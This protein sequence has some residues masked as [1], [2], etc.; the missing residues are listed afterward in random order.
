MQDTDVV[1]SD[2]VA[3]LILMQRQQ[4]MRAVRL[5]FDSSSVRRSSR[6]QQLV[7]ATDATDA[8]DVSDEPVPSWMTL[9]NAAHFMKFAGA[10]YGWP[11]F[12]YSHM[13][14]GP[15]KLCCTCR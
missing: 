7:A 9:E 11:F 12:L 3:G 10:S 8:A 14:C 2:I 5:D 6:L 15:C 13:L 4:Q 1:P